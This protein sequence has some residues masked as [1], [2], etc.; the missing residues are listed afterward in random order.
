MTA[1]VV[2]SRRYF[3]PRPPRGGRLVPGVVLRTLPDISIHALREEGDSGQCMRHRSACRISIHAL[4][5]EG[6]SRSRRLSGRSLP[7]SIHALR[8]E[9]DRGAGRVQPRCQ[10]SIH[11][12]REEGDA[13]CPIYYWYKEEFL[14]TPSARRATR[15]ASVSSCKAS[16]FY[17][18]PP[19]GGRPVTDAAAARVWVISI[20]ALREEGDAALW[21]S[22]VDAGSISIHALREEGDAALWVST[23]DTGSISIHALREEGDGQRA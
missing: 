9:G 18:R 15:R 21:V 17:P 4:R 14:S 23:V 22:T 12:L 11:A 6:D 2:G 20:H 7:I 5:E 13:E 19:R 8:E 3:Y 10:I 16:N 1:L